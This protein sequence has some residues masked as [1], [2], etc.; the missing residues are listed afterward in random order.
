MNTANKD[1]N[2]TMAD[3]VAEIDVRTRVSEQLVSSNEHF[4]IETT[5]GVTNQATTIDLDEFSDDDGDRFDKVLLYYKEK[6]S[7]RC[8]T[9]IF[10]YPTQEISHAD[11]SKIPRLPGDGA[12]ADSDINN[13][14]E[15]VSKSTDAN[16]NSG[17]GA[18]PSSDIKIGKIPN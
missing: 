13:E 17:T 10:G 2:Q 4:E 8:L 6:V 16:K 15:S 9:V 5:G 12:Q 3:N 11:I 1:N 18:N 14:L 7:K